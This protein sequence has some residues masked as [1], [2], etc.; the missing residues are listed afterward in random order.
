MHTE[1]WNSSFCLVYLNMIC[2]TFSVSLLT[3]LDMYKTIIQLNMMKVA[4]EEVGE[5]RVGGG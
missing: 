1:E 4:R 2:M 3:F 5:F